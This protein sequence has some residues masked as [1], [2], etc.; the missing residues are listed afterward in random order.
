MIYPWQ[1]KRMQDAIR[2]LKDRRLAHAVLVSGPESIGKLDFCLQFIQRLNC[3]SPNID[4][5]ACGECKDCHLFKAKTHPDVRLINIDEADDDKKSEQIKIDDIRDIN[6]FMN[7][8]RQQGQYK[9][10][11]INKAESMNINAA[12]ALLKT[13][14]EPPGNAILFLVSQRSDALLPTIK[15]RCQTWKFHLPNE[16]QS[17]AWLSE[18]ADDKQWDVVLKIAG[19]R[20]LRAL[21]LK[22][23]GLGK[24]RVK[25]YQNIDSL[26]AGKAK[27]T[28]VSKQHQDE[29]LEQLV[30]WQ[31]AWCGDLIRCHF[32]KQPVTLENPDFRRS[33]HSLV[34]RVDL[35][36][37][38]R[39]MDKLIELHRISSAPLNKRLFIEDMLV[40]CQEV[41]EQ[42]V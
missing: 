36:L 28:N 18:Q 33:L 29:P 14:E 27:V 24:N 41:L 8:S 21:A 32:D 23:S 11:C 26:L 38:F 31:Q 5:H 17:L 3:T 12:N 1:Y 22:Q 25:Y 7:L 6:Q 20:P 35:H 16:E 4:D 39:F 34:G 2:Y 13:L 40:R 15:S 30:M 42:P 37:L 19:G 10:V 9:A